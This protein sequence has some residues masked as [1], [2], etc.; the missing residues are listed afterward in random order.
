LRFAPPLF[1]ASISRL[2]RW[3]GFSI[4]LVAAKP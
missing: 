4:T 1:D 2:M 3:P